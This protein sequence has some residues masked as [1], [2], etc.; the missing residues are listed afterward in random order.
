M[1]KNNVDV[2]INP[3]HEI[4][5]RKDYKPGNKC[6]KELLITDDILAVLDM[7]DKEITQ[8]STASATHTTLSE[9]LLSSSTPTTPTSTTQEL[10][11]ATPNSI[12][13]TDAIKDDVKKQKVFE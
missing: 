9:I 5:F 11:T 12:T 13:A 8:A 6:E 7:F 3:F 2:F 1:V 10:A 4:Y